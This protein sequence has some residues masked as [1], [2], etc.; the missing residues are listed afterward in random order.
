MRSVSLS[1]A[2][3]NLTE[4]MIKLG[5]VGMV[6][7]GMREKSKELVVYFDS[8]N[9]PEVPVFWGEYPVAAKVVGKVGA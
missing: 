8:P 9:H 5:P 7:V 6:G 3:D 1:E 2:L 4:H